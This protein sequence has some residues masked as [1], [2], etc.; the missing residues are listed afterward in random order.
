MQDVAPANSDQYSEMLMVSSANET[1]FPFVLP[2]ALSCLYYNPGCRVE[3]FVPITGDFNQR[4]Q[5][6]LTE[7][8]LYYPERFRITS[9]PFDKAQPSVVRF[10][11]QPTLQARYVYIG[12][13]DILVLEDVISFSLE[14]MT[15]FK[16][17]YSNIVRRNFPPP[18]YRLTG[19]HFSEYNYYY[20]VQLPPD[21]DLT[22]RQWGFDEKLL[23][24][25]VAQKGPVSQELNIHSLHGFHLSHH[26]W[27]F[28]P[29]RGWGVDNETYRSAYSKLAQSEAWR[30]VKP[31]FDRR[32]QIILGVL[33]LAI[34]SLACFTKAELAGNFVFSGKD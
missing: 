5:S 23:Y 17:R 32:Y 31:H 3:I 9:V 12:D 18:D 33:D 11:F 20:P 10:I 25:I 29:R 2:Y 13:I 27:P 15:R 1:Y 8:A 26:G 30:A 6:G 21:V 16:T 28:H 7:I 19:L 14:A 4:Y 24:Q 22:D 34:E